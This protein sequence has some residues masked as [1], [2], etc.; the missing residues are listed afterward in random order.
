M[1][2]GIFINQA[3]YTKELLKKIGLENAKTLGILINPS[4]K[5]DKDEYG[6]LV[7]EKQY[8]Y[9]I[10][11]LLYLITSKPNIMFSICLCARYH[12]N[13]KESHLCAIKRIFR[14][15]FGTKN[16]GL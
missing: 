4:I 12:S 7:D 3:K 5:L 11:S 2:E 9:M 8:N 16:F 13:P 14:Y 15:L 6:K 1:K 10:G